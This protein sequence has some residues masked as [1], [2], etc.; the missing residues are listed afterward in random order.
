LKNRVLHEGTHLQ[1]GGRAM[2]MRSSS[3]QSMA[4]ELN[5]GEGVGSTCRGEALSS[6]EALRPTHRE[7][8]GVRWLDTDDV[9]ENR[10]GVQR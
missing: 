9:A 3:T 6:G 7:G 2:E 1:R 8:G 4:P 10:G 5:G